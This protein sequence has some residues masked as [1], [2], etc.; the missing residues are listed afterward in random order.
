M[1]S[2]LTASLLAL[3]AV[4]PAA[5]M[6][7]AEPNAEVLTAA[8]H[9][10]L[11]RRGDL[12]LAKNVWPIDVT[13]HEI[14][15]GARNALQMP[16]L[17]RLE[18]VA[19]SVADVDVD[20]EGTPHRMKVRRYALTD[21]G[22]KYYLKRYSGPVSGQGRAAA[23]AD[24]CAAR[25]SLDHIVSWEL[26]KIAEGKQQAVVTYTY[27]VD[28]APWSEDAQVQKVFPM[29]AAVLRGAGSAQLQEAFTLTETGWVAVD[30]QGS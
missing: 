14:D 29:V 6:R 20:D 17:E 18:L 21:T 9:A 2:I 25:L 19:S 8:M 15:I 16:V 24:F 10:Y 1:K 7:S 30:L 13:Q 22:R 4:G 5:C 27:R 3:A 23:N 12:C 26:R 11:A 28:A